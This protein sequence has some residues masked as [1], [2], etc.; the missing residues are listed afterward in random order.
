M[1]VFLRNQLKSKRTFLKRLQEI[2]HTM[3][4]IRP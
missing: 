2:H 1:G 4:S 3:K